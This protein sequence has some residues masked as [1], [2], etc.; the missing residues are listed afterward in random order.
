LLTTFPSPTCQ[1]PKFGNTKF[2]FHEKLTRYNFPVDKG[3]TEN[4]TI[5]AVSKTYRSVLGLI[6]TKYRDIF[7]GENQPEHDNSP[8]PCVEINNEWSYTSSPPVSLNEV[9]R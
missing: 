3:R 1:N 8:P 6:F 4:F 2:A 9:D 7:I 5:L